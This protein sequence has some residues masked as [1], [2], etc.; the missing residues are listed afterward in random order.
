MRGRS[1]ERVHRAPDAATREVRL[2]VRDAK[3]HAVRFADARDQKL[4]VPGLVH[5]PRVNARQRAVAVDELE[6]FRARRERVAAGDVEERP[7]VSRECLEA[8][9]A[10]P[11]STVKS[12]S[13]SA[14]D[15][16]VAAKWKP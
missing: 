3:R 6:L 13:G 7:G 14:N 10:E 1:A 4:P 9:G 8:P 2:V 5:A 16:M 12:G 11:I 15:G